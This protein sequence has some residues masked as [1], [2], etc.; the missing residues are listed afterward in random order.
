MLGVFRATLQPRPAA[1]LLARKPTEHRQQGILAARHG[2]PG[3]GHDGPDR[4]TGRPP[5]PGHRRGPGARSRR[6]RHTM[7]DPDPPRRDHRRPPQRVP[8]VRWAH[9][10]LDAARV[11]IVD[12]I[13]ATPDGLAFAPPK[14]EAVAPHGADP[15]VR[16][17]TARAHKVD[18]GRRRLALGA[19]WDDHDLVCERG[20]GR[21]LDPM[22]FTHGFGRIAHKAGLD[23]CA[24]TTSATGSAR[25]WRSPVRR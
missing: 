18:Q 17:G 2:E 22:S 9:V 20:D 11:R 25:R 14:V 10:D 8:G 1:G 5:R 24:C 12:P 23:E 6:P 13:V 3:E 21:P 7:G 4:T 19:D 15:A 16:G